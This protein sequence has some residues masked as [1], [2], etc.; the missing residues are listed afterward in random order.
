RARRECLVDSW[1]LETAFAGTASATSFRLWPPP[2]ATAGGGWE[3]VP[4][5]RTDPQG[6][7]PQ[8]VRPSSTA[9]W[10]DG[11]GRGGV[12]SGITSLQASQDFTEH[13]IC[14]QEYIV[15][16]EPQHAISIA[17]DPA[18]PRCILR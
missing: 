15:I 5:V 16:P 9:R 7:P 17:F 11:L 8:P 1:R 2:P 18:S 3:G 14:L 12:G 10:P 13:N 6:T 4:T